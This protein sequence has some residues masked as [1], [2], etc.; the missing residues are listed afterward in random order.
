MLKLGKYIV[1]AG[2]VAILSWYVISPQPARFDHQV[3]YLK[4]TVIYEYHYMKG[5]PDSHLKDLADQ[6]NARAQLEWAKVL[7]LEGLAEKE[8]YELAIPYIKRAVQKGLPAAL[9]VYG[10]AYRHGL[11]VE[12]DPVLAYQWWKLASDRGYALAR[13]NL[14]ELSRRL[15][16]EDVAAGI[17]QSDRWMEH[18][19]AQQPHWNELWSSEP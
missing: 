9:N 16:V 18:Y 5:L 11:G 4:G 15:N 7:F 8:K 10:T 14:M 19:L 13:N 3:I 17:E 12:K 1:L 6:G 2:L